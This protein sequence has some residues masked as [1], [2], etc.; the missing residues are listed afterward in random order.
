MDA[1]HAARLDWH[2]AI[3]ARHQALLSAPHEWRRLHGRSPQRDAGGLGAGSALVLHAVAQSDRRTARVGDVAV[4][5]GCETDRA[6]GAADPGR[7]PVPIQALRWFFTQWL[8]RTG[9]PR[10]SGTWRYDAG[11]KRIVL[12]V[13]QTQAEAPFRFRLG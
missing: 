3:L 9:V 13:R 2:G 7:G 6:H 1:A 12:T 4:R 5:R 10:V 11:A 8:N